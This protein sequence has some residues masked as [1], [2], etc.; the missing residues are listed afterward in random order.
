[1]HL[2]K[3]NRGWIDAELDYAAATYRELV[4]LALALKQR[5]E[6]RAASLLAGK[7]IHAVFFN[8]SI[9]TQTSVKVASHELGGHLNMLLPGSIY[10]PVLAG[11]DR[12]YETERVSDVARVLGRMGHAIAIRMYGDAS[13]W[14]YGKANRTLKTFS[15]Y[16]RRPVLNLE[17]DRF[18]PTQA[19]ADLMTMTEQLGGDV[20][21]KRMVMSWA[22]SGSH[23]KPLAVPQSAVLLAAKMGMNVVVAHPRGFELDPQVMEASRCFAEEA[24]GSL[25]VAHDMRDA[26]AGADIVYAKSW[27]VQALFADPAQGR[28]ADFAGMQRLF[29]AHA[30]GWTCTEEHMRLAK[31]NAKYMHCLPCDHDQEVSDSVFESPASVV[32]DQAENR[33]HA[34]KAILAS[35]L[36]HTA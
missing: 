19:L 22:Y 18:H 16:A 17:C 21:G 14:V 29:K 24:G 13:Q 27:G 1:M 7:T 34:M 30:Q 9:R 26:V 8:E 33:L 20:R 31:P 25:E 11:E 15:E 4:T 32:F 28:P 5:A 2:P 3:L 23:K 12:A 35:L 10:T 36:G 6:P